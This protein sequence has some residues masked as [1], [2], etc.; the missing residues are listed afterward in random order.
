MIVDFFLDKY[1][2]GFVVADNKDRTVELTTIYS[3]D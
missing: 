1:R 2:I 3:N